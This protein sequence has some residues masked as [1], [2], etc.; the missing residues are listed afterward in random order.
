MLDLESTNEG[1]PE[2]VVKYIS[3]RLSNY[4]LIIDI[5][6]GIGQF[7]IQVNYL[8]FFCIKLLS[9]EKKEIL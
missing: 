7:S 4:G 1:F 2:Q 8:H 3:K 6:S 9:L 5:F